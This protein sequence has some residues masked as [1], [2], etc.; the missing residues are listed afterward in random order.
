[1]PFVLRPQRLFSIHVLLPPFPTHY[2]T[3][4]LMNT[5]ATAANLRRTAGALVSY[6][7]RNA[8]RS[9]GSV[10]SPAD[11][12]ALIEYTAAALSRGLCEAT[13]LSLDLGGSPDAF[14]APA[15]DRPDRSAPLSVGNAWLVCRR[16]RDARAGMS[17]AELDAL[18]TAR[19][20][21][22]RLHGGTHV[23]E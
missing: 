9:C 12:E 7:V 15:L 2:L 4:Y 5:T 10:P 16:Y 19:V 13:E 11:I 8:Q 23:V 17:V 14:T 18:C 21:A 20:A 1:M 22:L 6:A 3:N